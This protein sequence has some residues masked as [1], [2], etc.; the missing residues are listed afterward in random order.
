MG[1]GQLRTQ[2]DLSQIVAASRELIQHL[3]LG[4]E[5]GFL[6]E[7]HC[8]G[9]VKQVGDPFPAKVSLPIFGVVGLI[10]GSVPLCLVLASVARKCA[11]ISSRHGGEPQRGDSSQGALEFSWTHAG[12]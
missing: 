6:D 9:D 3:A 11:K 7:V 1:V 10:H 8:A 12:C 5:V 2:N 4:Q